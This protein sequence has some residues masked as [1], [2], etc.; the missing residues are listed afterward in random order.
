MARTL[1]FGGGADVAVDAA[2]GVDLIFG[3][4]SSDE[5]D[6][7]ELEESKHIKIELK[8]LIQSVEFR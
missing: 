4:S 8:R 2:I 6:E 5:L 3:D 7:L 1:P